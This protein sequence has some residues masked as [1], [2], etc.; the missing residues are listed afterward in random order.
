MLIVFQYPKAYQCCL[1]N[2]AM[3]PNTQNLILEIW[4]L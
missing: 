2:S 4:G 1:V 3:N